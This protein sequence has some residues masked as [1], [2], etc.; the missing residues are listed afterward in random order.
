MKIRELQEKKEQL[1]E[2]M[3]DFDQHSTSLQVKIEGGFEGKEEEEEK[4][5]LERELH[6]IEERRD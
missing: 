5:R 2:K 6:Q 1:K 4:Q 3:A